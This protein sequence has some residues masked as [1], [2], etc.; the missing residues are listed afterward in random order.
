ML[1][2]EEFASP[3]KTECPDREKIKI[4]SRFLIIVIVGLVLMSINARALYAG[5]PQLLTRQSIYVPVYSHI[6]H[7]SRARPFNLTVTLS[8][9]NTDTKNQISLYSV[10]YYGTDGQLIQEYLKEPLELNILETIRYVLK[11]DDKRGG[12][13]AK[14]II[15]WQSDTPVNEPLIEAIMISTASTQ[16]ISWKSRGREIV[17]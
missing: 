11:S 1:N 16:G 10:D 14:F 9:R 6:Y 12:S 2:L 5:T 4:K 15:R 8:I 13:G 7:G 17:E 3:T